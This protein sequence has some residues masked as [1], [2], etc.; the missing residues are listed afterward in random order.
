[1]LFVSCVFLM[2]GCVLSHEKSPLTVIATPTIFPANLSSKVPMV[3]LGQ[4]TGERSSCLGQQS[5]YMK[6][7][8]KKQS[9][10][11]GFTPFSFVLS[12][13]C[14]KANMS[15]AANI[16]Q[17]WIKGWTERQVREKMDFFFFG[18]GGEKQ[19][20]QQPKRS[21]KSLREKALLFLNIKAVGHAT[22]LRTL[23]VSGTL[24]LSSRASVCLESQPDAKRFAPLCCLTLKASTSPNQ[25]T[26][27]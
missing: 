7:W 10:S 19:K 22:L 13:L 24:E 27:R 12:K 25:V 6:F 20:T 21:L 15:C 8:R 26:L 14:M 16:T 2:G 23:R 17:K 5:I 1:M 3:V 11:G 18:G 4:L 9:V